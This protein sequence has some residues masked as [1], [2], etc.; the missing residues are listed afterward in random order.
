MKNISGL[1]N[2]VWHVDDYMCL[3]KNLIILAFDLPLIVKKPFLKTDQN[4]VD[5]TIPIIYKAP[6]IIKTSIFSK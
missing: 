4:N 5:K 2:R 3:F 1:A 6:V